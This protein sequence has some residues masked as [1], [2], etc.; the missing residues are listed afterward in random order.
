MTGL[1]SH[2][3]WYVGFVTWGLLFLFIICFR[4]FISVYCCAVCFLLFPTWSFRRVFLLSSPKYLFFSLILLLKFLW[5]GFM[6][7]LCWV[8]SCLWLSS[9]VRHLVPPLS[10]SFPPSRHSPTPNPSTWSVF[11][12]C[13][14]PLLCVSP[15][16]HYD[17]P[18]ISPSCLS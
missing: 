9:L 2:D 15:Y 10:H 1:E 12:S 17:I 6:V 8:W 7:F 14:S 18:S 13:Y 5:A 16:I 3:I 11:H 4:F